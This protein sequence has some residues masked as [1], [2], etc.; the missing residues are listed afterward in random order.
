MSNKSLS[1]FECIFGYGVRECCNVIDLN[2][3]VKFTQHNLL[4]LSFLHCIC[5]IFSVICM[6]PSVAQ[7]VERRTVDA[8]L[9][10]SLGRWFDSGSKEKGF[11]FI[12][13]TQ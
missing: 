9:W 13:G 7:L 2:T 11:I 8:C 6:F 3:A 5:I 1:H 12:N 10:P 4:R